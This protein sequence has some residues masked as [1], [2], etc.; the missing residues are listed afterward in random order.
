MSKL[1]IKVRRDSTEMYLR[2]REAQ[3]MQLLI[4]RGTAGIS[5]LHHPGIRL[6]HYIFKL[7]GYGFLIETVNTP[8]GG[9]FSGHHA[10]YL[11][12]SSVSI[13]GGEA[14]AA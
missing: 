4:E 13:V 9:D 12:K 6:S 10:V 5:S 1:K 11:L 3:T 7:R 2:G 8:H 14:R